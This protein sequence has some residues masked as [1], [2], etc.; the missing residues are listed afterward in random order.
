[1]QLI[2][3]CAQP[4]FSVVQPSWLIHGCV[5]VQAHLRPADA[6]PCVVPPLDPLRKCACRP[7]VRESFNRSIRLPESS[8]RGCRF[9]LVMPFLYEQPSHTA[10]FQ[11][12]LLRC[13]VSLLYGELARPMSGVARVSRLIG[14]SDTTAKAYH[15][16]GG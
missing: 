16:Q 9:S 4:S 7:F 10:H 12:S 1:M 3:N 14:N 2:A 8:R 15:W 11:P 5:A 13:D 6:L